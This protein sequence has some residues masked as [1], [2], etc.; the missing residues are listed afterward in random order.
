[1]AYDFE[2]NTCDECGE[3]KNDDGFFLDT[4]G[5]VLCPKCHKEESLEN[6]FKIIYEKKVNE[7]RTKSKS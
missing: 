2:K 5:D 4:N 7:N 1:M 6:L 3:E